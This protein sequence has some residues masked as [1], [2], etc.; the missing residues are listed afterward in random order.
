MPDMSVYDTVFI[1]T[2]NWWSSIAPP[3]VS[4]IEQVDL[5][6][7]TIVPFCSN[8]GGGL[9]KIDEELQQLI[10]DA[11]IKPGYSIYGSSIKRG[12]IDNWIKELKL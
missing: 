3:V 8:G 2:P 10:H 11:V 1:G 7:K 12:Q 5:T 4:F 9:G 6:G